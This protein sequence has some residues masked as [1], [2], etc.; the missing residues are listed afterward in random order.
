MYFRL[1][2]KCM[3]YARHRVAG[4]V[5]TRQYVSI[6]QVC[7]RLLGLDDKLFRW[8]P[9]SQLNKAFYIAFSFLSSTS[10]TARLS[11]S[12]H[13]LFPGVPRHV[14]VLLFGPG[15]G[16]FSPLVQPA[17]P[18]R[19]V[20]LVAVSALP[21]EP[22]LH[23]VKM[24]PTHNTESRSN[25]IPPCCCCRRQ[26]SARRERDKTL[27]ISSP[28]AGETSRGVVRRK[29]KVDLGDW[30]PQR[31]SALKSLSRIQTT[32]AAAGFR[33]NASIRASLFNFPLASS[34]RRAARAPAAWRQ[35][36]KTTTITRKSE[37][38]NKA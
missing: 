23:H 26:K 28:E 18:R 30:Q 33:L 3:K 11:S 25:M 4:V 14:V 35:R 38:K 5:S 32:A 15:F 36:V 22:G 6:R 16:H 1:D 27:W 21:L 12:C 10:R 19:R 7:R 8:R 37:K 2:Q 29:T 20:G 9:V 13:L 17:A 24:E 31:R 34:W